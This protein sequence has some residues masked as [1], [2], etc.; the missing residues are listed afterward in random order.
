MA[1]SQIPQTAS[2]RETHITLDATPFDLPA[3]ENDET[4]PTGWVI[5]RPVQRRTA[6]VADAIAI[7]RELHEEARG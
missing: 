7:I 4:R 6:S 5:R 2:R 1:S 3:A